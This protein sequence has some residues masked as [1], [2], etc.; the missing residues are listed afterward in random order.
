MFPDLIEQGINI[1]QE[2]LKWVLQ[3]RPMRTQKDIEYIFDKHC[4][5]CPF[6]AKETDTSGVCKLCGCAIRK[7]NSLINKLALATTKCPDNPP[8]WDRHNIEVGPHQ[9]FSPPVVNRPETPPSV[10]SSLQ[11]QKK[12][13]VSQPPPNTKKKCCGG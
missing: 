7:D 5:E 12:E 10:I 9:V 13:E 3:G 4:S 2:V 6:L 8:K 11:E 1:T